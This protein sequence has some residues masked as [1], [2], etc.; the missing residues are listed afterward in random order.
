MIARCRTTSR[1][2]ARAIFCTK[3]ARRCARTIFGGLIRVD[4][5]THFTDAYQKVRNLLLSDDAE[6]NSMS[7]LEILADNVRC[8]HGA[9]S[10]QIDEDE[11]LY[12]RS[13]GI[14]V[15]V[16]QRLIVTGFLDEVV[17]RLDHPAISEH[18]HGLIGEKF[19]KNR[20]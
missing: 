1:R 20:G 3:C 14:P 6:A 2:I 13:R 5:H 8:T 10:G 18:L 4:P 15:P 16:A 12:L 11:L 19:S 7:G 17:Q 9:T